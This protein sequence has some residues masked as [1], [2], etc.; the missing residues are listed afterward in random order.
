MKIELKNIGKIRS[1]SV[2]LDGITVIAG[3]NNT[4]K[5]TVSKALYSTYKSF[6]NASNQIHS[7][8]I[9]SIRNSLIAIYRSIFS[10]INVRI[11]VTAL[12]NYI[13]DNIEE[14]K[15]T[16]DNLKRI[17]MEAMERAE[18]KKRNAIQQN[19]IEASLNNIHSALN[20]DE[21]QILERLSGRNIDFEFHSQVNNIYNET[22][23]AIY[24]FTD[25][26]PSVFSFEDQRLIQLENPN[27]ISTGI[28]YLD[29]P[30]VLDN[31][32]VLGWQLV[33]DQTHRYDLQQA[34]IQPQN[35]SIIHEI[36]VDKRLSEI[37]MKINT[38]CPGEIVDVGN[39]NYRYRKPDSDKLLDVSNLSTGLKT[40]A[41]LK[42]LL[43]N[44]TLEAGSMVILDEP[45]IHMHPEWQL[46]FAELIVLLRQKFNLHVLLTTH[47]PYFLEA[48]EIYSARYGVAKDCK[49]YLAYNEG[50]YSEITEVSDNIEQIY[51]LL[52]KPFQILEDA[53]Y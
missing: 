16:P 30:F 23:G 40:F 6:Y 13:L 43:R 42:T 39:Q 47:S 37:H 41:I 27:E 9:I 17:V 45:E 11:N 29:N 15:N 4:G 3:E 49:Y 5:S 38:I 35:N 1:A 51:K 7:E 18:D 20:M 8:R 31:L 36:L 24:L 32:S 33:P 12:S 53:R 48:I 21:T 50:E 34:L 28:I 14:Y 10:G 52:A 44:G 25:S 26:N 22:P 19:N 46:V 2:D